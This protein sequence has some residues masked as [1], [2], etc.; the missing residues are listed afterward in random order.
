MT[1]IEEHEL[2]KAAKQGNPDALARLAARFE[3]P[4]RAIAR[5]YARG[6]DWYDL[7]S[8]AQV[9]MLEALPKWNPEQ[10]GSFV[11]FAY[12]AAC[13]KV[14]HAA[15]GMRSP[16]SRN[17]WQLRKL[18][19][20]EAGPES[21]PFDEEIEGEL[22]YRPEDEMLDIIDRRRQYA[23][24]CSALN[25]ATP[26]DR[27]LIRMRIE[28]ELTLREIADALG[29]SPATVLRRVRIALTRVRTAAG[30]AQRANRYATSCAA[31]A[32]LRRNTST[33]PSPPHPLS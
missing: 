17:L 6:D 5:R 3:R 12:R 8:V 1:N 15:F 20:G 28:D 18:R 9:A 33:V 29:S 30:T 11:A 19:A 16:V 14:S 32:P 10:A 27:E 26:E 21:L 4:A 25:S 23:A 31:Q 13:W 22:A 2:A 24:L 7:V